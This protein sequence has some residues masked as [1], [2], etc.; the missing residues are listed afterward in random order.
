TAPTPAKTGGAYIGF[1]SAFQG[2][3]NN[4]DPSGD[5]FA[6]FAYD[7]FYAVAIAVGSI[8]GEPTGAQVSTALRRL[9]GSKQVA[10]V[11]MS[12]YLDG[13]RKLKESDGVTLDGASGQIRF[14]A[15]GDR[16]NALFEVWSVNVG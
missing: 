9:N 6:A 2:R 12:G 1:R 3:F 13:V 15:T 4:I 14:T 11:G 7:A 5:A 16:D 10:A 8:A